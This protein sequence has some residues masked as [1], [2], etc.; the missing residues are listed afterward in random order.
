MQS[1]LVPILRSLPDQNL[2]ACASFDDYE[3]VFW[4]C[5]LKY[6][7][8]FKE[9]KGNDNSIVFLSWLLFLDFF[10]KY[11]AFVVVANFDFSSFF[12]LKSIIIPP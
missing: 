12:S 7:Q 6:F 11:C 1:I 10:L 2:F 3:R 8:T 4:T 5:Y 9:T